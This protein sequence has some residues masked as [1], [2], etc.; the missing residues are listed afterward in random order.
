MVSNSQLSDVHRTYD[1]QIPGLEFVVLRV[2]LA[3]GYLTRSLIVAGPFLLRRLRRQ[4]K[5]A[6]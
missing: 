1:D 5:A 4:W 3:S 6:L 2:N